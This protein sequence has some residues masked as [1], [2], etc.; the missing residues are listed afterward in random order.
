MKGKM[1]KRF[2]FDTCAL[3][4][5]YKGNPKYLK[6]GTGVGMIITKLNLLEY[7]YFLIREKKEGDIKEGFENLN[8]YIIKYDDRTLL[9][10]AHMKFKH[11]K[12]GLSYVD[13]IGY[14]LAKKHGV[15]FLT[16][17]GKF[18]NLENV[19]FVA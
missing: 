8:N 4:E 13:C 2:F 17:D 12:E 18:R 1:T 6:Y 9:N 3:I 15:K 19:E 14:L 11:K 10:A 7:I 5:I 16:A